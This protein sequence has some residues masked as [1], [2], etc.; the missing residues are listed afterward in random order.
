MWSKMG[1]R[2]LGSWREEKGMAS[3]ECC[4]AVKLWTCVGYWTREGSR[5]CSPSFPQ[6]HSVLRVRTVGTF[7]RVLVVAGAGRVEQGASLPCRPSALSQALPPETI[8]KEIPWCHQSRFPLCQLL[9]QSQ[10]TRSKSHHHHKE[11]PFPERSWSMSHSYQ[12]AARERNPA[13][14]L[15][16]HHGLFCS[17]LVSRASLDA[18]DSLPGGPCLPGCRM[19]TGFQGWA[20]AGAF[21]PKLRPATVCIVT[22]RGLLLSPNI[23]HSYPLS[24]K[25]FGAQV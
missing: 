20:S 11:H 3:E 10:F 17:G 6:L 23:T 5:C 22:L 12:E 2:P 13:S 8:Q 7:P 24:P 9:S 25:G 19:D 1:L 16:D 18:C 4:E 21:T 15:A 14:S